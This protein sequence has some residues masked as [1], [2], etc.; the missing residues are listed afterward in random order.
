MC[1]WFFSAI[2]SSLGFF[3]FIWLFPGTFTSGIH[4]AW[5]NLEAFSPSLLPQ[6][7]HLPLQ[8]LASVTFLILPK[9]TNRSK[10]TSNVAWWDAA[11][12]V[13]EV[14]TLLKTCSSCIPLQRLQCSLLSKEEWPSL[15]KVTRMI[16]LATSLQVIEPLL[17]YLCLFWL[18]PPQSASLYS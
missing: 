2:S 5:S 4:K 9:F 12:K 3:S 13:A 6:I 7:P 18:Q 14:Y 11:D 1:L 16:F 10:V 15:S 8:K 17:A